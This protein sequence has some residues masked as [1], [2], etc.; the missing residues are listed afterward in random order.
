MNPLS[1]KYINLFILHKFF[2]SEITRA[3]VYNITNKY[4]QGSKISFD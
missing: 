2:Y 4:I 1:Y 3:L